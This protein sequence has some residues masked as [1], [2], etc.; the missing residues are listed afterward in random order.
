MVLLVVSLL[1]LQAMP[2]SAEPGGANTV[3]CGPAWRVVDSADGPG[4]NNLYGVYAVTPTDTMGAQYSIPY[5]AA[6][7]VTANP[8]DP[9]MYAPE[10]IDDPERRR[11]AQ[12]VALVPDD[13]MEE[14][15]NEGEIASTAWGDLLQNLFVL[16]RG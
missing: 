8:S 7:A 3:S 11:L 12:R 2:A 10:A 6:L 5:C 14:I 1:P 15:L 13:E 4:T 16:G 9:A